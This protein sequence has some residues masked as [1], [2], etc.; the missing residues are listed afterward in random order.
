MPYLSVGMQPASPLKTKCR[1][2][3]SFTW[4]KALPSRLGFTLKFDFHM[5]FEQWPAPQL[6]VQVRARSFFC[7]FFFAA[8]NMPGS[9]AACLSCG[10]TSRQSSH[11]ALPDQPVGNRQATLERKASLQTIALVGEE[12]TLWQ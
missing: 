2:G 12:E 10:R 7:T 5:F 3:F 11:G 4:K 1:V 6:I 9:L 8:W